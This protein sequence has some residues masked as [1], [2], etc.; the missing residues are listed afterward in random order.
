EHPNA[1][2]D[3]LLPYSSS[4]RAVIDD[5]AATA[6]SMAQS[7]P[8]AP[9]LPP[10]P[11]LAPPAATDAANVSLSD[12]LDGLVAEAAARLS[13]VTQAFPYTSI[14]LHLYRHSIGAPPPDG[15]RADDDGGGGGSRTV[16][17]R[18]TVSVAISAALFLLVLAL[19]AC[20][21]A[22]LRRRWRA[23]RRL[24]PSC[25][26]KPPGAGPATTMALTDVQVRL[27]ARGG[28][29]WVGRRA[30]ERHYRI[31]IYEWLVRHPLVTEPRCFT[32][33]AGAAGADVS[34]CR[35][36]T[37]LG[38]QPVFVVALVVLMHTTAP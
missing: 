11:P 18:V 7:A 6:V 21:V 34:C 8:G 26:A 16:P 23:K 5:L 24:P 3:V 2:M 25:R 35:W 14:L 27:A 12:P 20:L 29:W 17:W 4:Y 13:N 9:P 33:W 30:D 1:A 31:I 10:T 37:S 15:L 36:S 28:W 38:E 22:A 32:F 19:A